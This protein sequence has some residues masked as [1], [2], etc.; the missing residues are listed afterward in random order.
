MELLAAAAEDPPDVRTAAAA[1]GDLP[2]PAGEPGERVAGRA[3]VLAAGRRDEAAD[4]EREPRRVDERVLVR[5]A[6]LAPVRAVGDPVPAD[7]AAQR[8][9]AAVRRLA[10]G[11]GLLLRHA[12]S[13]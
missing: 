6:H 4:A 7:R 2:R 9:I 3:D 13:L 12:G 5:A 11:L 10:P 1:D 8:I